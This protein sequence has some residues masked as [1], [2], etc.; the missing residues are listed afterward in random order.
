[1]GIVTPPTGMV[2]PYPEFFT[3]LARL[4]RRTADAFEKAG[5]EQRFEV[6]QVASDL[7]GLLNLSQNLSNARDYKELEKNAGKM[8]QLGQFQNR[9]YEQHRSELEK[10]GP[11]DAWKRLQGGLKDLARHCA[12][13]GTANE[14]ETETL[15]LFFNSRQ[16]ISWL[17]NDFAP[18][19]DRLAQL[20]TKSITGE[21]LSEEDGKWIENYGITLA[22]FHFYYGNSYEVPRDD[23]PIVTRVFSNPLTSSMLYAGLARPQALYIIVPKGKTL[24]MYRGAVMAYREFVRPND[25]LLDDDSWR[26]LISKGQTPPAPP[27]TRSFYAETSVAELLKRLNAGSKNE[28]VNY[29]DVED[30][31]WQ[32]G[33]RATDKDL[34]ALFEMLTHTKGEDGR[35]DIVDGLAEIMGKLP[36]E[37]RQKQMVDLLASP[38]NLLAKAVARMLIEQPVLL[39]TAI[40]TSGFSRQPPRTRRLYCAILSRVPQQ[41]EATRK[42]LLQASQDQ[43]DGVRW[44]AVLAIGK[45]GW[46]D[47]QSQSALLAALNDSN[48]F[49]GAAA[50][51]SLTQLKATDAA[52]VLF[53]KLKL[54]LAASNASPAILQ[55]QAS[56]ITREFRGEENHLSV[57]DPERL[58]GR[59]YVNPEVAANFKRMAAMRLPPRPFNF[60]TDNYSLPDALIEAL[61]ELEYA[62]ATDELFKLRGSDYDMAATRALCKL[63]PDR[64]T[65]E[66]LGVATDKK[67]DS[68]LREQALVTL[69]TLSATNHV[70]ELIPLLDDVTP[71]V[72]S[73]PMPGAEWRVCDRAAASIATLLGWQQRMMPIFV[74]PEQRDETLKRVREWAKQTP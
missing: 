13:S 16:S 4:T 31:L 28:D 51:Y 23:F 62:P 44:Q 39:D 34:P 20:A 21:S 57:L 68:Y 52:P 14:A 5:L 8:E 42:L 35:G 45:L 30:I 24:Q 38:D 29:R 3:G 69:C 22:G 54:A 26:E 27:F 1:M 6:K 50:A 46:N 60:P 37:S 36:W 17:L 48:Q 33:S 63:A 2:A 47:K 55:Q 19:C 25:Q 10:D 18:V 61:G 9:Y 73:R 58:E 43:T 7:L 74:R 53:G 65:G 64:L 56:E 32:I 49:V 66:L 67:L 12:E 71:I 72:Y 40:L 15:R 41:T 11:R 70:R 59:L